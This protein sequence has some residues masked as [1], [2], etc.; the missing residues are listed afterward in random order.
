MTS[1]ASHT[2]AMRPE[3]EGTTCV[4]LD[5]RGLPGPA[6][7]TTQPR[8]STGVP[9]TRSRQTVQLQLRHPCR[10]KP[11]TPLRLSHPWISSEHI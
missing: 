6:A 7:G 3:G 1:H 2:I 8:F 4:N 9:S 10:P 11:V 5:E